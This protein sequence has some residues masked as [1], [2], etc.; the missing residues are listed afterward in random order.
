LNPRACCV[1]HPPLPPRVCRFLR[2]VRAKGRR[3]QRDEWLHG[4][5]KRPPHTVYILQND[6]REREREVVRIKKAQCSSCEQRGGGRNAEGCG[7]L[8]CVYV[9]PSGGKPPHARHAR[10]FSSLPQSFLANLLTC[11]HRMGSRGMC[12]YGCVCVAARPGS[13]RRRCSREK[14]QF[15]CICFEGV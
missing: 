3:K 7:R 2:G 13:A 15:A 10:P 4:F 1:V 8:C 9:C 12:V 14:A 6:K 5:F 11:A